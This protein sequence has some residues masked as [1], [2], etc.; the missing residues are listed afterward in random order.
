MSTAVRKKYLAFLDH[1]VA[2][3]TRYMMA[4]KATRKVSVPRPK[5][6]YSQI[7]KMNYAKD[8]AEYKITSI[9]PLTDCRCTSSM[10]IYS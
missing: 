4:K 8:S 9:D 6:A 10:D 5:S 7:S 3:A 1:I 2:D